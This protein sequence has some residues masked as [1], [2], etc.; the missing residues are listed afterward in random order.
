MAM[1]AEKID[2]QQDSLNKE[3]IGMMAGYK[4]TLKQ[5]KANYGNYSKNVHSNGKNNNFD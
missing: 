2:N 3:M 4:N 5:F 1:F